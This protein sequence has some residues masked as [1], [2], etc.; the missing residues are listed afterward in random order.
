[1]QSCKSSRPK[2]IRRNSNAAA[3]SSALGTLMVAVAVLAV[4]CWWVTAQKKSVDDR[5]AMLTRIE[6]VCHGHWYI[7]QL[8]P[9]VSSAVPGLRR[10]LGDQGVGMISLP[11][12]ADPE[13]YPVIHA[14]FPEAQLQIFERTVPLSGIPAN[15]MPGRS[16]L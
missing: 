16:F 10:L 9:G 7:E 4:P 5:I 15:R 2:L 3:F 6:K 13:I 14:L 8:P 11:I 1:M 12:E